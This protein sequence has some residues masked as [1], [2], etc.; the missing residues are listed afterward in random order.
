MG[1]IKKTMTWEE[2][3]PVRK[4][5]YP[6]PLFPFWS[7]IVFGGVVIF[8]ALITILIPSEGPRNDTFLYLG[9]GLFIA[10]FFGYGTRLIDSIGGT[11]IRVG[12]TGIVRMG[13]VVGYGSPILMLFKFG[14]R[15]WKWRDIAYLYL[16]TEQ[17]NEHLISIIKIVGHND[18]PL[19]TV[20]LP[21]KKFKMN[22]LIAVLEEN[23]C[24]LRRDEMTEET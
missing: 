6:Y 14:R 1:L 11:P 15:H 7:H 18:K 24:P 23:N 12:G 8:F 16:H 21:T 5:Y 20:G 2:P 3:K 10:A 17:F 4:K 22:E 13:S 19:G 9:I